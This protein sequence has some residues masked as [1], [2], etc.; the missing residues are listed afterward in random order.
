VTRAHHSIGWAAALLISACSGSLSL[1]AQTPQGAPPAS[2]QT[3]PDQPAVAPQPREREPQQAQPQPPGSEVR[4][5]RPYRGLFAGSNG[6]PQPLGFS[7]L[8]DGYT[9]WDSNVLA[10]QPGG[11]VNQFAGVNGRFVGG[12]GALNYL[13][14][15][16]DSLFA[17]SAFADIRSY[18]TL[19]VPAFQSY[20]GF[21]N[22]QSPLGR[23]FRVDL[24]QDAM[25][26][27][28]YQLFGAPR[29]DLAPSGQP[30]TAP[31]SP[32]QGL[33]DSTT[34]GFTT[35]ARLTQTLSGKSSLEYGYIRR[36]THYESDGHDFLMNRGDITFRH[37]MTRAATL[38]LGY[39][40]EKADYGS[41]LPLEIQNIDVGLDY[42]KPLGFSRR[43]RVG[44]SIGSSVLTRASLNFYRVGG[45]ADLTHEIGRTW[46]IV[47]SYARGV[48]LTDL[49]PQPF[50]SD[51]LT[52]HANGM[53]ARRLELTFDARYTTGQLTLSSAGHGLEMYGASSTVQWALTRLLALYGTYGFYHHS[54][55]PGVV[56]P[57]DMARNVD[58]H[59]VR[60]GV[61]LWV[62]ISTRRERGNPSGIR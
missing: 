48:Q 46:E 56:V 45:R 62:P 12:S 58:R 37:G 10:S 52:A 30:I 53:A 60:G 19:D 22:W 38:R 31:A 26:S 55:P 54:I 16:R 3:T 49:S 28:F 43:T 2:G 35:A 9:G 24:R 57:V 40:Y 47:G 18:P 7:L 34:F 33:S 59:S 15:R 20:S 5:E 39:G 8:L 4:P 21:L 36:Q 42:S 1:R 41:G 50:Y 13:W 44:F 61:R 27:S 29:A 51:T 17:G 32:D 14:T 6:A 23:R 25:H 11:G